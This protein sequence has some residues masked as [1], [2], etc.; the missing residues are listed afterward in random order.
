MKDADFCPQHLEVAIQVFVEWVMNEKSGGFY[1]EKVQMM[2]HM[3]P[4]GWR[5]Y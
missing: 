4:A 1:Q 3:A 2:S 5:R